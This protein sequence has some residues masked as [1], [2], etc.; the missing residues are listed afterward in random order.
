[1]KSI[2]LSQDDECTHKHRRHGLRTLQSSSHQGEA[3]DVFGQLVHP[4]RSLAVS[5]GHDNYSIRYLPR[6][7]DHATQRLTE[8]TT[9]ADDRGP[10]MATNE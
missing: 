7:D 5:R 1:M 10:S 3:D 4:E 8:A 6:V 9:G 2:V